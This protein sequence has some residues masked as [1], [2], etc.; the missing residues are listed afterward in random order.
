MI[1]AT[2]RPWAIVEEADRYRIVKPDGVMAMAG[3]WKTEFQRLTTFPIYI[4]E[5]HRFAINAYNSDGRDNPQI[6]ADNAAL[7]VN[8]VNVFDLAKAALE[9]MIAT[10]DTYLD[11]PTAYP[12]YNNAK[13]VLKEM[14]S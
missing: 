6:G 12:A 14:A 2:K 13:Q 1:Q 8:A 9:G 7:V 11:K 5:I 3:S 10:W 4:G